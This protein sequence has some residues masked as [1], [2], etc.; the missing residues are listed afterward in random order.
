MGNLLRKASMEIFFYDSHTPVFSMASLSTMRC[1]LTWRRT[2][3]CTLHTHNPSTEN[4]VS[5]FDT[6]NV[7]KEA[8]MTLSVVRCSFLRKNSWSQDCK[9]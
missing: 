8:V 4:D 5:I 6:L 3:Q 9:A 1:W 7:R 2:R